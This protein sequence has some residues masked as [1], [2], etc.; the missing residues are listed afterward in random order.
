[1]NNSNRTKK[2][3]LTPDLSY[4]IGMWHITPSRKGLGVRGNIDVR[5]E[6]VR[7]LISYGIAEP[8]Q[9]TS[10]DEEVYVQHTRYKKLFVKTM[11]ERFNRFKYLNDYCANFWAG[12]CDGGA[13]ITKKG[14]IH[15]HNADKRDA[16]HL[17]ILGFGSRKTATGVIV[18][19]TY[20]FAFF[21]KNY[22]TII[23]KKPEFKEV[24]LN[25]RNHSKNREK[26]P[27]Y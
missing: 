26:N 17:D 24:V 27:C 9:I 10:T 25:A 19:N 14:T 8:N 21:I 15:I 5:A 16:M 6:F 4:L 12:V 3:K 13:T 23:N 2:P 11:A 7:R 18:K 22:V 1:M 20:G